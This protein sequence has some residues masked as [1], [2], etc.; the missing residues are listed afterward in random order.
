MQNKKKSSQEYG[1]KQRIMGQRI[2]NRKE[3]RKNRKTEFHLSLSLSLSSG[4]DKLEQRKRIA[5]CALFFSCYITLQEGA[6]EKKIVTNSGRE[7]AEE[8]E[9]TFFGEQR[10]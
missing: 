9:N 4:E 1:F 8:V 7:R 3:V 2:A 6:N 5:L 10:S